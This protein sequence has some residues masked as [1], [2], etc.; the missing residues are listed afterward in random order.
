MRVYTKH[1]MQKAFANYLG[2]DEAE[3]VAVASKKE[4]QNAAERVEEI[5]F[6]ETVIKDCLAIIGNTRDSCITAKTLADQLIERKVTWE[7]KETRNHEITANWVKKKLSTWNVLAIRVRKGRSQI[8]CYRTTDLA[9]ILKI[10]LQT[11]DEELS[12]LQ[13]LPV[14]IE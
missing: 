5:K 2:I 13:S 11:L 4:V 10:Q 3:I 8:R 9:N 14:L 7:P 12:K 6:D 1:D